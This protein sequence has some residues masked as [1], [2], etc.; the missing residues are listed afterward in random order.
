M[1]TIVKLSVPEMVGFL[2][3]IGKESMFIAMDTCT[4]LIPGEKIRKG[5]PFGIVTKQA[6]VQGALNW[7]YARKMR[8]AQA[9]AAG[10]PVEEVP[11]YQRKE[12]W[13][14]ALLDENGNAT[15][16]RVNK[17]TPNNGEFYLFYNHIHT[18]ET[19]FTAIDGKVIAYKDL[20]PYFYGKGE[21]LVPV[22][23]IKLSNVRELRAC[24]IVVKGVPVTGSMAPVAHF[25]TEEQAEEAMKNA[26]QWTSGNPDFAQ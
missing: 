8:K 14:T 16:L 10:V 6:K 18:G 11:E 4:V 25:D 26:F 19:V 20:E 5:N 12:V 17:R 21:E 24:G 15:V 13:H 1:K 23:C 3:T 22:R 2:K 9:E 7:D